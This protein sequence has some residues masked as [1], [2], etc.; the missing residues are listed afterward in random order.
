MGISLLLGAAAVDWFTGPQVAFSVFY[1]PAIL[2]VAWTAGRWPGLAIAL[3]SGCLWLFIELMTGASTSHPLI[4]YWNGAVRLTIFCLIAVL[5]AEVA[6]RKRAERAL[7]AQTQLLG[8]IL[9]SMGD[10][11]VVADL[12]GNLSLINP[13]A[14][15]LLR[16]A[17]DNL[18]P[19]AWLQDQDTYHLDCLTDTPSHEHPLA[20]ARRGESVEGAEMVLRPPAFG[21]ERWLSLSARPLRAAAG[22]L[23][24]GVMVFADIT[25]RRRL[26]R[27]IAEISEREQRRLGQDLHDGLC[28]H[29]VSAAFAARLLADRLRERHQPEADDAAELAELLD[30]AITQAREVARGLYGVQ[31]EAGGLSSALEALASQVQSRHRIACRFLDH[32]PSPVTGFNGVTDL[33]RIAQEAVNNSVKH[34]RARRITISLASDH[35]QLVLATADDGVGLPSRL[36]QSRGLGLHMMNYRARL[37]G[38]ALNIQPGSEGGTVVTCTLK[39]SNLTSC[40]SHG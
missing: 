22:Q 30:Q 9:N 17:A 34:A 29:L 21:E 35:R 39:R 8:S 28:Q 3:G 26:E 16:P 24:G 23:A 14:E 12:A 11:V 19:A 36:D 13:A 27:Q 15:R 20:R 1:L 10:G 4:P 38:A 25:A 33:F 32:T 2:L 5:T 31:L 7:Q 18:D 37:I 40:G 6:E